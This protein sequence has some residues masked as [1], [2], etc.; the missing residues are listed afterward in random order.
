MAPNEGFVQSEKC[1]I[2]RCDIF[3]VMPRTQH[4][5]PSNRH[6][7]R[8]NDAHAVSKLLHQ[9]HLDAAAHVTVARLPGGEHDL[10]EGVE[11]GLAGSR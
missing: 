7:F 8:S 6:T 3:A 2:N 4:T 10:A 9:V 1:F 5:P 11:E